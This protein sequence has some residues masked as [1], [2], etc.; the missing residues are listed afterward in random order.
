VIRIEERDKTI[1]IRGVET[2]NRRLKEKKRK[3]NLEK[4]KVARR[5][6]NGLGKVG[7]EE[8]KVDAA[9][10]DG[11]EKEKEKE[12]E[13]GKTREKGNDTRK[14]KLDHT[15]TQPE[16]SVIVIVDADGGKE[17]KEDREDDGAKKKLINVVEISI[18]ALTQDVPL[19]AAKETPKRSKSTELM[20]VDTGREFKEPGDVQNAESEE[21]THDADHECEAS[22]ET[23]AEKD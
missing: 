17:E 15:M 14:D 10:K 22:D 11:R 7:D 20:I 2:I 8:V 21:I 16:T 9:G 3:G 6:D 12:R 13:K 23:A 1:D 18:D 19:F 5:R 4:E